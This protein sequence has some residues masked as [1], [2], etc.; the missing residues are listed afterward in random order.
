MFGTNVLTVAMN[1]CCL[2]ERAWSSSLWRRVFSITRGHTPILRVY[3]KKISTQMVCSQSLWCPLPVLYPLAIGTQTQTQVEFSIVC[4]YFFVNKQNKSGSSDPQ[5]GEIGSLLPETIIPIQ[6][7]GTIGFACV[8]Y[9]EDIKACSRV[10][11]SDHPHD[12]HV[13]HPSE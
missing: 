9:T 7:C 11:H 12:S 8:P 5:Y 1:H 2:T 3:L 10:Q 4:Q 13:L 6:R